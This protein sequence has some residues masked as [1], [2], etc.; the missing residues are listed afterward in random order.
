MAKNE[1]FEKL[2]KELKLLFNQ[3]KIIKQ[4]V[5]KHFF[6]PH[7]TLANKDLK[8]RDFKTVWLDFKDRKYQR[9][10]ELNRLSVLELVGEKW[11]IKTEIAL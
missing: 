10:F 9:H 1:T 3:Q 2:C 5:E 7:I 11:K 8:K 4:R 6:V